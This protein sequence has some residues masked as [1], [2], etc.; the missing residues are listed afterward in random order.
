MGLEGYKASIENLAEGTEV[1]QLAMGARATTAAEIVASTAASRLGLKEVARSMLAACVELEEHLA[2]ISRILKNTEELANKVVADTEDTS[3]LAS[4]AEAVFRDA[5]NT[6]AEQ[7]QQ[8]LRAAAN[9]PRSGQLDIAQERYNAVLGKGRTLFERMH[10][11]FAE[12]DELRTPMEEASGAVGEVLGS[13][14]D[15]VGHEQVA[16]DAMRTMLSEL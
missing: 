3:A 2:T 14:G 16:L 5:T 12:L 11:I 13:C 6:G 4:Q 7:V 8:S 9:T 15:I 10:E 1:N